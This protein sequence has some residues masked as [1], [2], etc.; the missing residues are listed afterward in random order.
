[1]A[2]RLILAARAGGLP[3]LFNDTSGFHPIRHADLVRQLIDAGL[4]LGPRA[5]LEEMPEFRQIIPY[6][7]VR[8]DNRILRY[9]RTPAG[10][11]DRLHGKIS[12]GLGGHIDAPDIRWHR[13]GADIDLYGTLQKAALREINEEI[14]SIG[15]FNLRWIGAITDNTNLVGHVHVGVVGV[16]D[17]IDPP[18][19]ETEDAIGGAAFQSLDELLAV[20]DRMENWSLFAFDHLRGNA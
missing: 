16:L 9:I 15:F 17:L 8:H 14:G 3:T 1:M 11:E 5:A 6:V 19:L 13:D 18:I 10:G 20:R 7:V 2:K 4:W 12:I